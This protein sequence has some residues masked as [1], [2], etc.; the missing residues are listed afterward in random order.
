MRQICL[1]L[2][3]FYK[4]AVSPLFGPVCRFY[5]SCSDY[6]AQAVSRFGV[7]RGGVLA[8]WR[9]ARCHPLAKAGFDPVPATF[10]FPGFCPGP[11]DAP[12]NEPILPENLRP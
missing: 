1:G 8:L 4:F 11:A 5:P 10:R 7:V 2:L 9:L 12:D 3:R 6:A